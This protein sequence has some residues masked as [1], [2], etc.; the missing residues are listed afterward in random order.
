[1]NG[2]PNSA[3][4]LASNSVSCWPSF[5]FSRTKN[6]IDWVRPSETIGE[7]RAHLRSAVD[8]SQLSFKLV[9]SRVVLF[10]KPPDDFVL[11]VTVP[12]LVAVVCF[13]VGGPCD[14]T[15]IPL[16]VMLP[17]CFMIS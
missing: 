1:M 4:S 2:E 15:W 11:H 5:N 12:F 10:L 13:L 9:G 17:E 8:F 16:A 14:E 3:S 6:R 7:P